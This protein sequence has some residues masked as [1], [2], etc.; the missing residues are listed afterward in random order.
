MKD[1]R[2]PHES[3]PRA[4]LRVRSDALINAALALDG[5]RTLYGRRSTLADPRRGPLAEVVE[6]LPSAAP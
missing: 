2:V 6:I 4:F 3:R 1:C 5:P